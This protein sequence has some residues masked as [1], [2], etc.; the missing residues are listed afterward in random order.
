MFYSHLCY[1]RDFGLRRWPRMSTPLNA[2]RCPVRILLISQLAQMSQWR[3]S[4]MRRTLKVFYTFRAFEGFLRKK[5]LFIPDRCPIL[6]FRN[7]E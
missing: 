4:F 7:L 3:R 1:F 2:N 5:F 6:N